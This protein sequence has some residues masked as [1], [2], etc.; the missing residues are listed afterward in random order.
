[1]KENRQNCLNLL[2][3]TMAF[4]ALTCTVILLQSNTDDYKGTTLI[5]NKG[6]DLLTISTDRIPIVN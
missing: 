3:G 4:L 5:F 6:R 2:S 1:M